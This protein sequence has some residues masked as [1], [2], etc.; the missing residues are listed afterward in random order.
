MAGYQFG[1]WIAGW[2]GLDKAVAGYADSL[3][4][5]GA[6]TAAAK[7]DVI[8]RAIAQGA[9]ETIT[10]T[11]AV[12]FNNKAAQEQNDAYAVSSERLA[13]AQ[14]EV[15]GLSDETIAAIEIAKKNGATTAEITRHFDISADALRALAER[16]KLAGKAAEAHTKALEEQ[17]R[18]AVALD[19]AYEK[20]MSDTKNA[21]Q[22][23]IM[24]ADAHRM[25]TEAM[26]AKNDAAAGWIAANV[27]AT[28]AVKETAAAEA[29]YLAEQ[30]ALTAAT[31]ALSQAHAD[32]GQ[33]AAQATTTAMQGYQGLAQQ[34]TLTGDAIKAMVQAY[35]YANQV[36]QILST[37]S[38][39]TTQ[40]QYSRD[41]RPGEPVRAQRRR[42]RRGVT[43]NISSVMGD[44]EEI[45]RRVKSAIVDSD[46]ATGRRLAEA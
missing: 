44:P 26:K 16:Q 31:D 23:A 32:G 22:L 6:E 39:F 12:K 42:R 17:K 35:Q 18:E 28:A 45:G 11:E 37:N 25:A 33:A 7:Q 13:A 20:L 19:K 24:E 3:T 21:N 43:V 41:Q 40:S 46:R 5:I 14:K 10:Y 15:R 38:L 9:R 30:D 36:N 34:V 29:A 8:N 4:N 2:T 1:T 27:K